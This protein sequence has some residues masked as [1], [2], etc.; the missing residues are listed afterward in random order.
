[1]LNNNLLI[2]LIDLRSL[3]L[4][5]DQLPSKEEMV[6]ALMDSPLYDGKIKTEVHRRIKVSMVKEA[7]WRTLRDESFKSLMSAFSDDEIV[8]QYKRWNG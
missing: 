1:L 2:D 3:C 5:Q 8:E 4:Q 6:L 7:A